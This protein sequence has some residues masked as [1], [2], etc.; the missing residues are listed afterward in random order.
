MVPY[1][2]AE[3]GSS[4]RVMNCVGVVVCNVPVSPFIRVIYEEPADDDQKS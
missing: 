2:N 3:V 1:L 4:R